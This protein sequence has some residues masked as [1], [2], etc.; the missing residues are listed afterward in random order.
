MRGQVLAWLL[1]LAC[2]LQAQDLNWGGD[3]G[4]E[5]SV[6][7]ILG[8]DESAWNVKAVAELPP[9]LN[10]AGGAVTVDAGA[11][12][13]VIRFSTPACGS[14]GSKAFEIPLHR[15]VFNQTN[16]QLAKAAPNKKP[17]PLAMTEQ[18]GDG[19]ALNHE[20]W[21]SAF[22][23]SHHYAGISQAAAHYALSHELAHVAFEQAVEDND[24]SGCQDCIGSPE[25]DTPTPAAPNEFG[26]PCSEAY[27]Y[28]TSAAH[29]CS[30][31]NQKDSS[32][33]YV[34][35]SV[36]RTEFQAKADYTNSQCEAASAECAT[37]SEA[38][39]CSLGQPC[40]EVDGCPGQC[41]IQ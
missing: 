28:A 7:P 19:I 30:Q 3:S 5:W 12:P 29:L 39:A 10:Y 4:G 34:L 18:S 13:P 27:A 37:R 25:D 31:A 8:Q 41:V 6:F 11:S 22:N 17:N 16:A 38:C 40:P 20:Y 26:A 1:G 24:E 23:N 36:Q 15:V 21:D 33:N 32:G 14:S 9:G 35:D 2:A